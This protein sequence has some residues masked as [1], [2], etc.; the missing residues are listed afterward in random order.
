MIVQT[1][2][3]RRARRGRRA[4]P[5]RGLERAKEPQRGGGARD[6]DDDDE[7]GEEEEEDMDAE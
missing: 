6:R 5:Q 2:E 3:R 7:E 4:A 1:P